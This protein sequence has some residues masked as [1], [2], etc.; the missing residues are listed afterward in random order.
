MGDSGGSHTPTTPQMDATGPK[1]PSPLSRRIVN[2]A[3]ERGTVAVELAKARLDLSPSAAEERR[4]QRVMQEARAHPR[5]PTPR[6]FSTERRQWLS[7]LRE[8]HAAVWSNT[9][10]PAS[11]PPPRSP[12]DHSDEEDAAEEGDV[13]AQAPL[14]TRSALRR[15]RTATQRQSPLPL[16]GLVERANA[17]LLSLNGAPMPR[18]VLAKMQ[19]LRGALNPARAEARST[20]NAQTAEEP[21][22][23]DAKPQTPPL[24]AVV[25]PPGSSSKKIAPPPGPRPSSRRIPPPPGPRPSVRSASPSGAATTLT[26]AQPSTVIIALALTAADGIT[27]RRNV[28]MSNTDALEALLRDALPLHSR[29]PAVE[30]DAKSIIA[31]HQCGVSPCAD[32]HD[33]WALWVDIRGDGDQIELETFDTKEEAADRFSSPAFLKELEKELMADMAGLHFDDEIFDD[34]DA[35]AEESGLD[36]VQDQDGLAELDSDDDV[37]GLAD[38]D[39]DSDAYLL[40]VPQ[41]I[42]AE[43]SLRTRGAAR[44]ARGARAA[45]SSSSSSSSPTGGGSSEA[46]VA[47]NAINSALCWDSRAGHVA[48]GPDSPPLLRRSVE[49]AARASQPPR[50]AQRLRADEAK[51]ERETVASL[52]A[53]VDRATLAALSSSAAAFAVAG[54]AFAAAAHVYYE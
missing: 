23:E 53:A 47:L 35:L 51:G 34:L 46:A 16:S 26:G 13:L 33:R 7:T 2:D 28:T 27:R 25:P 40:G 52:A 49:R 50:A 9:T 54:R 24:G 14:S 15:Q 30:S 6:N 12:S 29:H 44:G 37:G 45:S 21:A 20:A 4:L 36:P 43:R 3:I 19:P 17:L 8:T 22:A 1:T 32:E 38:D 39:V 18:R 42:P 10:P 11:S 5:R 31:G 41:P 48:A